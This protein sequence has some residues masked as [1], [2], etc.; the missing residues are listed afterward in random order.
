MSDIPDFDNWIVLVNDEAQYSLWPTRRTTT[1]GWQATR[2]RGNRGACTAY[3]DTNL[4]D[5][6]PASLRADVLA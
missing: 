2:Q 1:A 6:T 4:I 5:M 3:V